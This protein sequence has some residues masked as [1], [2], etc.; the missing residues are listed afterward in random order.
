MSN[1]VLCALA[2]VFLPGLGQ[3]F[4]SRGYEAAGFFFGAVLAYMIYIPAGACVH[5]W[6][7]ADAALRAKRK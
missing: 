4:E 2:S 5:A 1:V 6:A 3:L 7:V